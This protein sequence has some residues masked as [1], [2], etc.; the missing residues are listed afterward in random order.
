MS[1]HSCRK[2]LLNRWAVSHRVHKYGFVLLNRLRIVTNTVFSNPI[3]ANNW[4]MSKIRFH[5]KHLCKYIVTYLY[6]ID[7]TQNQIPKS[8]P[9]HKRKNLDFIFIWLGSYNSNKVKDAY[10][11][12]N[13]SAA[14]F[15]ATKKKCDDCWHPGVESFPTIYNMNDFAVIIFSRY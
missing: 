10:Y 13:Y 1:G 9:A 2:F 11:I 15:D 6:S 7:C 4:K 8:C 12:M 5:S 3:T 14:S